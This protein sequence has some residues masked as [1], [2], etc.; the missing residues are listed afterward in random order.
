MLLSL[1]IRS[2]YTNAR[3]ESDIPDS[4]NKIVII[5]SMDPIPP[6][7]LKSL[8]AFSA[9]YVPINVPIKLNTHWILAV[10]YP[11]SR[12]HRGRS[13]VYDSHQ[14]NRLPCSSPAQC[15]LSAYHVSH[16]NLYTAICP[17][18][19]PACT[20]TTHRLEFWSCNHVVRVVASLRGLFWIGF[21]TGTHS[22]RKSVTGLSPLETFVDHWMRG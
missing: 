8:E 9:T 17:I 21:S 13:E 22:K 1:H 11:G 10:L 7:L 20:P 3:R 4:C 5:G 19:S 16:H 18:P 12:G 6:G 15:L 2:R 14:H